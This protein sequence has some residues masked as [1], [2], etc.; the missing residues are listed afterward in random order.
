MTNE[1]ANYFNMN[2]RQIGSTKF[3]FPHVEYNETYAKTSQI[4]KGE[5]V[6]RKCEFELDICTDHTSWRRGQ[7]EGL[8][9]T[10]PNL[11]CEEWE[12]TTYGIRGP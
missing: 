5:D 7:Y 6:C 10:S 3:I 12:Q 4:L 2:E 1:Y 8:L 9:L 11:K